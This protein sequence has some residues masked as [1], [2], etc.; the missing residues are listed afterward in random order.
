MKPKYI[1][2]A[3]LVA[4]FMIG[5]NAFLVQRDQKMFD[6]YYGKQTPKEHYCQQQAHFHPDCN[7]E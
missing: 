6:A 2:Y 5:Y 1:G 7:V 3:V 4:V